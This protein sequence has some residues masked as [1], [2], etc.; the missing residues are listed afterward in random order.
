M[1]YIDN[2]V[3]FIIEAISNNYNFIKQ[4]STFEVEDNF[5]PLIYELILYVKLSSAI[6]N[7][8]LSLLISLIILNFIYYIFFKNISYLMTLLK[9]I[10]LF[11]LTFIII[12]L[13]L[14]FYYS[15]KLE[16]HLGPYLYDIKL[17]FFLDSNINSQIEYFIVFS[18]SLSDAIL[19][20]S[21]VTGLICLELLAS[22]NLFKNINNISIFYFFNIF[23][24][25][26]VSTNNILIMFISFEL[27]F[28]PTMYF[29]YKLGYSNKIDK[30]NSILFYW[31]LCGSFSILC[32]LAYIYYIHNTLNF[33]ILQ[34]VKFSNFESRVIFLVILLGFGVKIPLAP[35]HFW[36]LKVHVESP[37]SFSIFLSG[38]L[39]KSA[40]YC[41]FM[42]I[43]LFNSSE[44][45][46]ILT[47]WIF[48]SLIVATFGLAR[49]TDVK[50][51]IAWATVQEMTF[52]L[53]FLVFKQIFLI[54][55]CVLFVILHGL[56]S[57][58]M[59]YLVDILQR[60]FKTRS[61]LFIKGLHLLLPKLTKHIWFLILLFS[62]FPLTAKFFIEWSLISLMVETQFLTLVYIIL[63][64]NFTGAIF[65]CKIMF[66]IIYGVQEENNLDFVETQKKEYNMLNFLMIF[67]LILLWLIYIL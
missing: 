9:F 38:F 6:I 42:F 50:K 25:I 64:V 12:L 28:L 30:A 45:Y 41:L 44:N 2:I 35:F 8:T 27:I 14:K 57:S 10:N 63:F 66:T 29:V 3:N 4:F 43:T 26:M 40:L 22:K 54:H 62:G 56:M 60:R 59:F 17:N 58:Y 55:T 52:M 51:L 16:Q 46:Y 31:T 11:F 7:I 5:D 32:V 21:F 65:F 1:I 18:S 37:T 53:L 47:A 48:Y 33:V 20:L 34:E 23:V 49:Q 24:V 67:I 15:L 36:L 19:I 13:F 39:V 61:L